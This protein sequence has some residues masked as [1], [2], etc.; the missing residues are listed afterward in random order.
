MFAITKVLIVALGGG[1][2]AASRYLVSVWAVERFGSGFPYGTLIVNIAG[3][4]IIGLFM[5][6]VTEKFEVSPEWRLLIT[7]GFLG[8]LT[9]FSSFSYETLSL[10]DSDV[11]L[12]AYNLL[13][14]C[15]IGFTATWLGINLARYLSV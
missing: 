8:G 12:A 7:T 2:G 13:A 11:R 3:C 6:L 1:I 15:I 5:V 10:L 4:F 14:N 9:T